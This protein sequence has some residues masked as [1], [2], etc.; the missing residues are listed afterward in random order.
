M[1]LA[2]EI[3]VAAELE[4][5]ERL[6]SLEEPGAMEQQSASTIQN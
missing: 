2:P 5:M 3:S 6:P 4:L 1:L